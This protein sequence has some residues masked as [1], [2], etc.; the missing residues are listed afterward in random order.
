M[1]TMANDRVSPEKYNWWCFK[2]LNCVSLWKWKS[3]EIVTFYDTRKFLCVCQN[4]V[5]MSGQL[6]RTPE[7]YQ[8]SLET[9]GSCTE[10]MDFLH[11]VRWLKKQLA[12]VLWHTQTWLV[13]YVKYLK[14]QHW[15]YIFIFI[16]LI[17]CTLQE[18]SYIKI[19]C[20]IA[21]KWSYRQY[22]LKSLRPLRMP[23]LLEGQWV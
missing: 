6:S 1:A 9:W 12:V 8:A 10:S 3:M 11:F 16:G 21:Q 18:N 4:K 2:V 13:V 19:T 7:I 17:T 22:L 23:H 5:Q 14:K 20:G 15:T